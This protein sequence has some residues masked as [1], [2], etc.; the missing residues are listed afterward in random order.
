MCNDVTCSIGIFALRCSIHVLSQWRNV[1]N[2]IWYPRCNTLLRPYNFLLPLKN[3]KK[4]ASF[5]GAPTSTVFY[6]FIPY[7]SQLNVDPTMNWP[8]YGTCYQIGLK[9]REHIAIRPLLIPRVAEAFVTPLSV[10]HVVIGRSA[11]IAYKT[12]H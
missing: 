2:A 8:E 5:F 6:A 12:R 11:I 4:V 10:M 1:T 9:I 3:K 7:P